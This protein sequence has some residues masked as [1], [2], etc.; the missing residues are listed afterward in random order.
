MISQFCIAAT[1]ATAIWL[2]QDLKFYRRRWAS[3][4]GLAGQPFWFYDTFMAQQWGMFFLTLVFTAAWA[5]GF[6]NHWVKP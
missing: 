2:S 5:K 1:G 6:Y 3:V 4:A